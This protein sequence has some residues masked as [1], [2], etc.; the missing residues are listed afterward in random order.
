MTKER[1]LKRNLTNYG[2][3]E[4]A[5]Y[6]RKSFARSMG[7]SKDMLDKPIV[8]IAMTPSGFNS[9]HRGMPELVDAVSRGILAAGALPRPFPTISLGEVFL[10]PTSMVYRNLMAMDTEEMVRAQPMDAVVLIGGCDKTVP[11]QLM[12]AASANIPAIQLV[13]GPMSTGRHRGERLGACTDCRRFWGKYRANEIDTAEITEIEG[14]LS[15]TSGTCGVMGTASTMACIAETLGMSLPDT[16]AIPS[17]HSERLVAAE[18]SGQAIVQLIDNPILPSEIITEKSVE[19]AFRVLMAISGSTNAIVHLTAVAGRLGIKISDERLNEISD[20]TPVLVNLKPVGE[21][22]M[23]D[24]Y[25]AGGLRAVLHEIKHLLHLDTINV[26]GQ[27]L[28]EILEEP[29]E[30]VDRTYIK[31]LDNPVSDVGGLI[32]VKG[33]IA[34]DGAIFKRAAATPELFEVEGRA[35]VFEGLE[36]LANRIDDPDLDVEPNDILVL[37]NAG[38]VA[39]GMPEA[40]YLPIPKKLAQKGVKDMVR[41]SDARMSGTAFGTILLHISPEAGIGGPLAAV[42]N[43]DRIQFSV[44]QKRIT[45]LVDDETIEKRLAT[46]EPLK[47]PLRGYRALYSKTVLQAPDG[48]DFDFLRHTS[49]DS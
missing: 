41:I 1:G 22:Y 30:W 21:G 12:G 5:T 17:V 20:E 43:G 3:K 36:D 23:E 7:I 48:C 9:C 31:S 46:K 40:G 8:G 16:A 32:S 10:S 28:G 6:L 37:K 4:F 33:N 47:T 11:A 2:D 39:A 38:P 19:N 45:L 34:P 25:A 35:V 18:A 42:E 13:T 24:F 26:A 29:M 44:S 14:K 15:T 49:V 27:T